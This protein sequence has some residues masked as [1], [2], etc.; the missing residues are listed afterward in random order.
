[1]RQRRTRADA[2]KRWRAFGLLT[3]VG[4][5]N[6]VPLYY[7]FASSLA[8][9]GPDFVAG[10]MSPPPVRHGGT[11]SSSSAT[12]ASAHDVNSIIATSVSVVCATLV[13]I[14]P[15]TPSPG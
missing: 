1:V 12:A 10:R 7:M 6:L 8:P 11:T 3:A 15:R 13:A 2:H 5:L 14:S 9:S 4:A